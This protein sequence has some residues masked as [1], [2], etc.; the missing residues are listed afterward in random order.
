MKFG[1]APTMWVMVSVEF[2]MVQESTSDLTAASMVL[3]LFSHQ[4]PE[5]PVPLRW[6][7]Y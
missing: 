3:Q 5:I 6:E 7:D 1:R 4:L 2:G